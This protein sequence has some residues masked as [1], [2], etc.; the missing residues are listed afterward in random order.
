MHRN[1]RRFVPFRRGIVKFAFFL[2]NP[3]WFESHKN[4][5][6]FMGHEPALTNNP[7]LDKIWQFTEP[8]EIQFSD[9]CVA[10]LSPLQSSVDP[11]LIISGTVLTWWQFSSLLWLFSADK[12]RLFS[13]SCARNLQFSPIKTL[14]C[15]FPSKSI[16]ESCQAMFIYS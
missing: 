15:I 9:Q 16:C 6:L 8:D 7:T 14:H 10:P 1:R 13:K 2:P 5:C 12:P 11:Y 3:I 4:Q